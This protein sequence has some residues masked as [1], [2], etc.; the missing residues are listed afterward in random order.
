MKKV[1]Q[2]FILDWR[3]LFKAPLALL[4]VIALIIL[5]SLYAW[6]N[7]K[8]LWDPY[9]NTSGIKVAVAIDDKGTQVEIPG[10]KPEKVNVGEELRKKL[11]K[12]NKL[13]WTFVSNKQAQKGV[14]SGKYYAA[15][16]I[17]KS[18]SKDMVSVVTGEDKKPN[19]DYSVNQKINAIAP[20]MTEKGAT[21]VVSQIS[22][23][24]IGTIS[25][26][27]LTAFNQA[28]IDL[29]SE[30]PTLRRLK[31]KV[32]QVQNA[33]PE[34]KKMGSEAENLEQKLPELKEKV[35]QV[36]ELNKKIPELNQAANDLLRVEEKLPLMDQLGDDV[37]RLQKKI[38]EIYQVADDVKEVNAHIGTI[39]KTVNDAVSESDKA[40][41]IINE[42]LLAVPTVKQIADD[43]SH[44]AGALDQFVNQIDQSFNQVAPAIKTNLELMK[45]VA[46]TIKGITEQ[47][48]NGNL[49][50]EDAI[51][52]LNKVEQHINNLQSLLTNQINLLKNLNDT[53]PNHPLD[54]LIA[55]LSSFNQLLADQKETIQAIKKELEDGAEPSKELVDRLN[56]DATKVSDTLASILNNYDS[57]IV[58]KIQQ[59]LNQIEKDVKN[60]KNLLD[61]A[62]KK[63]P[64]IENVLKNAK[65][66]LITGRGFLKEF[67]QKMPQIEKIL[68]ETTSAINTKL[69]RVIN[70]I[71][72]AANFYKNDYPAVK[73]KIHKAGRFIRND[74]PGLEKEINH[75]ANLIQEKMPEFEKAVNIASS[76]SR[77]ELPQF[78]HA[79]NKAADKI[80]EFDRDYDLQ[81]IIKLLRNDANK[82]S[83]FIANPVNLHQTEYYKI[84][85]YGSASAP[86]Y[87]ALCLWV[88]ALLLISLLR[89][90]VAAPVG[91][92][93][94]YHRYFGRLFTFLVIGFC[95]A[96]VV[97]LGNIFILG[98]SIA[99]P[100]LHVLF[101]L[102]ISFV[103]MIIVYTLVSL[104]N[105]VGKGAA[106]VLLVLQISGAGGNFPIQ[107]SPPFF[108]AIYPFLPFTYAV[109]LLRESVGGVY[110]PTMWTDLSVLVGFAVLFIVFGVVF[111]KP[112][113]KIVPKLAAK[114]RKSKLIH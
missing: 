42:A 67:Q 4:L 75:A 108:Q 92:Y 49:K 84:P 1:Y 114:T 55:D 69:D 111:K 39:K 95:Q 3:R 46:D 29:E 105:N 103:F 71:N 35:N 77:N 99:E 93:S 63:I 8:A 5:P 6:F 83:E 100:L 56:R 64:D 112:L 45:Q 61:N 21:T 9:S 11:K 86:F 94:N 106:I 14:K 36:V 76:L 27:V 65:Q 82:D 37:L 81:E 28:G 41:A 15:I 58:P 2:I 23:E 104:F 51:R 20:K 91:M 78:D 10:K 66:T 40:L 54:G 102:F 22:T 33:M 59:G 53:L 44:Y 30:L 26:A 87:T 68:A 73:A 60:G 34:I 98:V 109:S 85:N 96:L 110:G 101:S 52:L 48:K 80:R 18:F 47:L 79:I 90:D 70:G 74:L 13:G 107:V 88:G 7:I 50:P 32:F 38:P 113:D 89:V 57:V 43:G 62:Q 97:S 25:K 12:N 24:F 17:P 16:H 72:E 31:S 19:V